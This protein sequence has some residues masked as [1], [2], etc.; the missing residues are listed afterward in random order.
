MDQLATRHYGPAW[1]PAR[2]VAVGSGQK[3]LR[4]AT[5]PLA[6]GADANPDI[7][8]FATANPGHAAGDMLVCLCPLTLEN[9]VTLARR[10]VARRER[11]GA[12]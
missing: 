2:G 3:R 11:T 7:R 9:W 6:L 8:F 10:A 12:H 5:A 1:R 4:A